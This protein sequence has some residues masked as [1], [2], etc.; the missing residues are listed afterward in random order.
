[1]IVKGRDW[2]IVSAKMDETGILTLRVDFELYPSGWVEITLL[3]EDL[4][5]LQLGE[6]LERRNHGE[7]PSRS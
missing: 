7:R 2:P 5:K 1:M 4:E 3:N 6:H